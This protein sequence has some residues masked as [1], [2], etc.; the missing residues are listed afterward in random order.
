MKKF[1]FILAAFLAAT[2]AFGQTTRT[3]EADYVSGIQSSRDYMRAYGTAEDAKGLTKWATYAD[4]AGAL[5]V[6]GTGGSPTLTFTRTTSSPLSGNGSFLIT[7]GASNLQGQGAAYPFTIDSVDQGHTQTIVFDYY[8]A[9]GTYADGDQTVYIYDVTNSTVIQPTGY[10]ISNATTNIRQ[11]LTFQAAS[12]STSYRLIFHTA[13]TSSTAYTVKVDNIKIGP[14]Q[15]VNGTP[16]TDWV[17]YTPTLGFTGGSG[18]T[19]SGK[20]RRVGDSMEIQFKT[21]WSSIFTG[22]SAT[23]AVPTGYTIDTGKLV[24]TPSGNH[25]G[26]LNNSCVLGD[27][28][29][30]DFQGRMNYSSTTAAVC[31]VIRASGTYA[32]MADVTTTVPMTWANADTFYGHFT[33]PILGWSSNVQMSSDAATRV[34]A[35]SLLD[36]T[37]TLSSGSATKV[38]F[39]SVQFDTHG[40]V[41]VAKDAF[42]CPVPGVYRVTA[43][44]IGPNVAQSAGNGFDMF[45]YKNGVAYGNA[46][47]TVRQA[48]A[49]TI[50]QSVQGS[51]LVQ[52]N[53]GD[54]LSLYILATVGGAIP[55]GNSFVQFE[56]I[57]GPAQIA[58]SDSISARY[59]TSAGQSISDGA[60]SIVNYGTQEKDLTGSVT[61]GASW[62]FTAPIAGEY[63]VNGHF[64]FASHLIVATGQYIVYLYKNGSVSKTMSFWEADSANNTTQV[65]GNTFNGVVDLIA[66]DTIDVRILNN[67]GAAETLATA[68][69]DNWVSIR[70]VGQ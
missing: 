54:A 13:S 57:S 51:G 22:G 33:V 61:V 38:A 47:A 18:I 48:A 64:L 34:V 21:T 52:C 4:A 27:N 39:G 29:A 66:G 41:N 46:F 9:S 49:A 44:A 37:T 17:S 26:L 32:D 23:V 70:R 6:D 58:A 60:T 15:S 59:S 43:G 30:G 12:N 55:T 67:T 45:L 25:D 3:L 10:S 62:K 19:S 69:K 56:R 8:I 40:A 28:S 20:W 1:N 7:K 63:Q 31:Q 68:V 36:S 5:P 16:V 42:T 24:G 35:A 53:G 65:S 2:T 11:V 50:R 14:Q